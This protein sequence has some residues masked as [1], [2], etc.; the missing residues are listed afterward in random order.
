MFQKQKIVE[1]ETT[2]SR[3]GE[4]LA[5]LESHLNGL[6][7]LMQAICEADRHITFIPCEPLA[8]ELRKKMI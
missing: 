1:L 3:L 4:R 5:D 8:T 7:K 2:L 6:D